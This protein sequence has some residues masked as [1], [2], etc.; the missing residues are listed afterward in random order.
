VVAADQAFDRAMKAA[1]DAERAGDD[2][3]AASLLEGDATKAADAAI[4]AAEA[5][6]FETDWAAGRR[7]SLA[8]VL[9]ARRDA[10]GAYAKALKG[11]DVNA[12]LTAVTT[13][14]ALQKWAMDAAEAAMAP[15]AANKPDQ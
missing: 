11:D 3:K 9:H 12:K 5:A 13:Q 4:A 2:A 10:I 14:L 7:D 15:P 8:A 1:D 6:T